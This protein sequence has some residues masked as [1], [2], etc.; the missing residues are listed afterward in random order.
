MYYANNSQ[1]QTLAKNPNGQP[2]L[3]NSQFPPVALYKQQQLYQKSGLPSA[4]EQFQNPQFSNP[5]IQQQLCQQ[6]LQEQVQFRQKI[7][8][9]T[10]F[11]RF[12]QLQHFSNPLNSSHSSNEQIQ[13]QQQ[14]L[15]RNLN[16]QFQQQSEQ[17]LQQQYQPYSNFQQQQMNQHQQQQQ[18]QKLQQIQ[19]FQLQQKTQ[20]IPNNIINETTSK[21]VLST[22]NSISSSSKVDKEEKFD[23]TRKFL[24]PIFPFLK[25]TIVKLKNVPNI[26][27]NHF[28][29]LNDLYCHISG[30]KKNR[31]IF[32]CYVVKNNDKQKMEWPFCIKTIRCNGEIL[33]ITRKK[34]HY[35]SDGHLLQTEGIDSPHDITK[36]IHSNDN[37]IE[38]ETD[39][40][41]KC[42]KE[43]TV[44]ALFNIEF[45]YVE[46]E[47]ECKERIKKTIFSR[48]DILP[49]IKKQTVGSNNNNDD[50]LIIIDSTITVS[51]KCPISF[52]RIK[53]PVRGVECKHVQ[54]FE[55]D[56]YL[57]INYKHGKWE[58]PVCSKHTTTED[59]RYDEWFDELLKRIPE[60]V[61]KVEID[62]YGNYQIMNNVKIK[63]N[64]KQIVY[65]LDTNAVE[66]I[67]KNSNKE[68]NNTVID[69]G[70]KNNS[71]NK[72]KDN[73]Q[74]SKSDN[75]NDNNTSQ[76]KNKLLNN[77]YKRNNNEL[78][79]PND[80]NQSKKRNSNS[81]QGSLK[82]TYDHKEYP[83]IGPINFEPI[84]NR[85]T[86][87][88]TTLIF[89]DKFN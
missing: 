47:E 24:R 81:I 53:N 17:K 68:N 6:Q 66:E 63:Q 84:F 59:L 10:Q 29:I 36:F 12:N 83:N 2:I 89:D 3:L 49:I 60:D 61:D 82:S 39:K 4:S 78:Q 45:N 31:V 64:T 14:Q 33:N 43:E 85:M 37:T 21:T 52:S 9:Q 27:V 76:L 46:T 1:V 79:Y 20:Q 13:S 48:K 44:N 8:Q 62:E 41:D 87:A 34:P 67:N 54:A 23:T 69:I 58:C 26:H 25:P 77:N 18:M 11:Q 22:N 51:L 55:L 7:L 42:T 65:D 80:S 86:T 30:D 72:N 5:Q 19:Q 88:A 15:Y 70:E 38:I 71:I 75:V 73:T 28:T 35:G 40:I 74:S 32:S 50:D 16:L 57:S 56:S